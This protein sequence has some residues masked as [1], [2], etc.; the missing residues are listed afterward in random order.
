MVIQDTPE[1]QPMIRELKRKFFM[2]TA[3]KAAIV[4]IMGSN[5]AKPG[6]LAEASE[7][8]SR[9]HI[10]IDCVSQSLRQVNIQFLISRKHY[11]K[12]IEQL[13]QVLCL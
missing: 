11:K 10:N 6:I 13:N 9:N 7:V 3:K 2:V 5:I 4:C 12:A 1:A 8:L